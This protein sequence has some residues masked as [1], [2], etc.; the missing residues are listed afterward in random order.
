MP[1]GK[2]VVPYMGMAECT[3]NS[4]LI[5]E[6]TTPDLPIH[7]SDRLAVQPAVKQPLHR[8]KRIQIHMHNAPL[9]FHNDMLI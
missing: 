5:Q 8:Q 6:A 1:Q 3:P 2:A 9:P 7:R 4:G